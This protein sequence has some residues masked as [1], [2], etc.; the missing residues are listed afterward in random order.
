MKKLLFAICIVLII[1]SC[2]TSKQSA[3]LP[4]EDVDKID[5]YF[6]QANTYFTASQ[7]YCS[8][9]NSSFYEKDSTGKYKYI[10]SLNHF[11]YI[12]FIEDEEKYKKIFTCETL[13]TPLSPIDFS[14]NMLAVIFNDKCR[15]VVDIKQYIRTDEN[16]NLVINVQ[17]TGQRGGGEWFGFF[18]KF[19][20]RDKKTIQ[21]KFFY[22]FTN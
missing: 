17:I 9:R 11:E 2:Q 13:K 18:S 21:V 22:Y 5:N 1:L 20:K 7:I 14:Q 4:V 3:I 8:Y 6:P 16:D 15:N 10:D 19:K 12:D